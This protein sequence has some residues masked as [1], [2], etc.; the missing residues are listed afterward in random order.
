MHINSIRIDRFGACSDLSLDSLVHGINVFHGP[1]GSGK[2]T[3]CDFVRAMFYGF[4]EDTRRTYLPA[5]SRGFGGAVTIRGTA[6]Q[7]TICRSDDGSINGRLTIE[8]EDG[9]VIGQRQVPDAIGG[10]RQSTYD[11]AF[12]VDFGHRVGI[13]ALVE[14][15]QSLGLN[16]LGNTTDVERVATVK[17]VLREKRDALATIQRVQATHD[18]LCK[19]RV[20]L[21]KTIDE[22]EAAL[23]RQPDEAKL[24]G[25]IARLESRLEELQMQLRNLQSELAAAAQH[26]QGL[27][28]HG[29]GRHVQTSAPPWQVELQEL[30][31]QLHRWQTVL[32]EV[33]MRRKAIE[34]QVEA[35][36]IPVGAT[37]PRHCLGEIET[38]L[39]DVQESLA[40][41]QDATS[42]QGHQIKSLFSDVLAEMR[43]SVYRMCNALSGWESTSRQ[44][45]HTS[46]IAHLQRCEV[47]LQEAIESVSA[48]KLKIQSEVAAQSEEVALAPWHAGLCECAEHPTLESTKVVIESTIDHNQLA[49]VEDRIATLER[50]QV[51]LV[52]EIGQVQRELSRLRTQHHGLDRVELLDKLDA[53][54]NEF[55][56]VEQSMRDVARRRELLGE[57]AELEEELRHLS[58]AARS[59]SIVDR[60][61]EFL[62]RL[63]AG[64]LRE[65]EVAANEQ[66]W[67]IDEHRRRCAYHQLGDGNRDLVYLSICLA[68]AEA[69]N[70]QGVNLPII[71]KGVFT[72]VESKNVPEAAELLRDFAE[73]GHQIVLFTR[74]EHVANVFGL[75]NVAVRRLDV[76]LWHEAEE[77]DGVDVADSLWEPEAFDSDAEETVD[78]PPSHYHLSDH[79]SIEAATWIDASSAAK[80]HEIGVIRVGDLLELS[81]AEADDE[82]QSVGL[83]SDVVCSWQSQARL[84]CHVPRLR[85]YDARILVTCGITEP[86][87]L[88]DLSPH[89]LREMLKE[90]VSES[91]G[92]AALLSGTEFELSRVTDWISN[93]DHGSE[94][95]RNRRAPAARGRSPRTSRHTRRDGSHHGSQTNGRSKRNPAV[96][97][98]QDAATERTFHLSRNDSVVDAPSIGE[99]TAERLEK[100]GIKSVADLLRADAD[101]VAEKVD[102]RR[103]SAKVIRQW[104]QQTELVCRIPQLRGHD[105]QI[106]V[107]LGIT[108]PEELA[109]SDAEELWTSVEPFV[110]TKEGKRIIRNGKTPDLEEVT[111]WI[112]CAQA[113]RQLN[114]A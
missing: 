9:T 89:E 14:E 98:M 24:N 32:R 26:R 102:H 58:T 33:G 66:V 94:D 87:Q 113:A 23:A 73:Q 65:L 17:R 38:Q 8:H 7:Q 21:L 55:R 13:G 27:L 91:P 53:A 50:Q 67:V 78:H 22:L 41:L 77:V 95:P 69:L 64:D 4:D 72:H 46:E 43:D 12:S 51:M 107:A 83:S 49:Q 2:T 34:E 68:L 111:E 88:F 109:G 110:E 45:A 62:R 100:V 101:S 16:L 56:R 59:S 25:Q 104:Q 6:G 30:T 29:G 106:L 57:I 76:T 5:E 28:T 114:A 44:T 84:V 19:R 99:R 103:C 35:R 85:P 112:Q 39:E 82:L 81:L 1:A 52:T 42:Y 92:Q 3:I 80:L 70:H 61:S 18:E 37:N 86:E 47:E 15:A 96:V 108:T 79:D 20:E 97:K 105:A 60:A 48:Q 11:R 31:E 36:T 93:R 10:A 40:D 74:H 54:R 71:I 75:L 90:V 63:T